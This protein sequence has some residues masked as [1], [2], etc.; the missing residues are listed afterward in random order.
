MVLTK[1]HTSGM[2]DLNDTE[3]DSLAEILRQVT[4]RYDNLF[5]TAFPYTMGF[6]QHP[7]DGS[8]HPAW[9]F[10]AHFYPPLL[11][12]ATVRKFRVGY[13]MLAG[14]QRDITA[15]TAAASLRG[16]PGEH[17]LEQIRR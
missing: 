7:T 16:L 8:P 15:E 2:D 6:H 10:H 14:P 13:E 9:H 12:S 11:R 4:T 17:Y 1:R 3:R 5:R